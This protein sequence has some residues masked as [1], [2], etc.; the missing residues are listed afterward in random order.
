LECCHSSSCLQRGSNY[1]EREV[2]SRKA[3]EVEEHFRY[4]WRAA[5]VIVV[6]FLREI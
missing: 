4:G 3:C 2:S 6:L 5:I 1:A